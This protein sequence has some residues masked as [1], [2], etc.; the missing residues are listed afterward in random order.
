M[1]LLY[2]TLLLLFIIV[3]LFVLISIIVIT[4]NKYFFAICDCC[5]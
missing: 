3:L 1:M 5:H 4:W 2:L